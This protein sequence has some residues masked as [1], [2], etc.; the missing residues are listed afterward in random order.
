MWVEAGFEGVGGQRVAAEEALEERGVA[1]VAEHDAVAGE[2]EL[3][4]VDAAEAAGRP[5]RSRSSA[6]ARWKNGRSD[7]PRSMPRWPP[8]S[9]ASRR[10]MPHELRVLLEEA[11]AGGD[12][13]VDLAASPRG[14]ARPTASST[15]IGPLAE[16]IAEDLGV[17]GV[18]GREVVQQARPADAD[19][20]GDLVERRAVVARAR[21]SSAGP[22][23]GSPHA[24]RGPV[25]WRPSLPA[26]RPGSGRNRAGPIG[27]P[28]RSP[29]W[30]SSPPCSSR[31][32]SSGRCPVRR[33]AST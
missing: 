14:R 5:S 10:T 1:E 13:Q 22:R 19:R 4:G 23:R 27:P 6:T 33:P 17:D 32:S 3:L 7:A 9:S 28:V 30:T 8:P 15:R 16:A 11:E 18:L 29:P 12:D 21:R 2:Q 20:L 26:Y 31:T 25:P 24:S